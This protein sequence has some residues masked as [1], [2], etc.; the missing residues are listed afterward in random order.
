MPTI[1]KI[2]SLIV[3]SFSNVRKLKNDIKI[4][5]VIGTYSILVITNVASINI[6]IYYNNMPSMI[7]IKYNK[8]YNMLPIMVLIKLII[9][10][11]N[12]PFVKSFSTVQTL[13]DDKTLFKYNYEDN[14]YGE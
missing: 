6:I 7:N 4:F 11:V 1:A 2:I 13:L 10:S 14:Y 12:I 9:N 5:H 8:Y 3:Y